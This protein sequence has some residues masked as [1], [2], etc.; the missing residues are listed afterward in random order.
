MN[1]NGTTKASRI[2]LKGAVCNIERS[3]VYIYRSALIISSII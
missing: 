1:S 2:F 3:M